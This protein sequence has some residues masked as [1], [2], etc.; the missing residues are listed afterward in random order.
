MQLQLAFDAEDP[1][2]GWTGRGRLGHDDPAS[3]PGAARRLPRGVRVGNVVV[4]DRSRWTVQGF[5]LETGEFI[6]RLI[7]GS[8]A[9][10]RFR[11]R[12]IV[13]IER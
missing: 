10:R 9:L 5:D 6:C 7:G 12:A 13:R 4:V 2:R 8:E 3:Q 11:V 1:Q